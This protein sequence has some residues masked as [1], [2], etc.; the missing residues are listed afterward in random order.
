MSPTSSTTPGFSIRRALAAWT[1]IG[2][3]NEVNRYRAAQVL[4]PDLATV[5][6]MGGQAYAAPAHAHHGDDQSSCHHAGMDL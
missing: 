6:V 2:E 4:M 3:Y 1:F 5:M